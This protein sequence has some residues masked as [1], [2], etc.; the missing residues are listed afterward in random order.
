MEREPQTAAD[1][2]SRKLGPFWLTPDISPLNGLTYFVSAM[3][4]I[5]M[6]AAL[7][8]LQPIMMR[9]VG[10]ERA[11][12]GTLSG[13]LVFFQECIVLLITPFV[14][15]LTDKL[16]RK[17]LLLLGMFMLGTTYALYPF[18]DSVAMMYA[19]RVFF[20]F[21]VAMVATTI[22]IVSTDYVQDR[23]RGT[24]VA[25][26]SLTQGIG[27]FAV[28][29][30]LRRIPANLAAGGASE[31]EIARILFWGCMGICVGVLVLMA[32][33][34]SGRKPA[35]VDER[36]SLL[37]RV[38][39]GIEAARQNPRVALAYA[40]AFAA[41]GDLL[42]VSTFGFLWTQQ[43]AEDL[44]LGAADGLARGGMVVGIVQGCAL[45]W[46]PVMGKILNHV[47]RATGVIIAFTLSAVGYTTFGLIDDPFSSRI[48]PA[49]VLLGIGE[50]STMI[51]A[52][53]LIG[54]SAPSSIRGSVLGCYALCGA[55][56]LLFASAVGGRL[57]DL[58]MAGGPF[59]QMGIVNAIVLIAAIVVRRRTG[60]VRKQAE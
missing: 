49:A 52:N 33:G 59:V 5:P 48:I 27:I 14:G 36:E 32:A 55:A 37:S 13:D 9:I 8:F 20:A 54:Q 26:A 21:G 60:P 10:V 3:L 31:A 24:W 2:R 7:S 17:P 44:G 18:A 4:A 16:G 42:V 58:W 29:Q 43:A 23:S 34:L 45:L 1:K 15:A 41:R 6:L 22:T 12:Q 19:Y 47:D 11:I 56:G 39:G 35:H 40:T 30:V 53:A 50:I 57:F 51:S 25:T 38:R 46:A 28:T